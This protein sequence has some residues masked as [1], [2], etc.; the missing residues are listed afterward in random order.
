MTMSRGNRPCLQVKE[1]VDRVYNYSAQLE[2]LCAGRGTLK[3]NIRSHRFGSSVCSLALLLKPLRPT[4]Y[5]CVGIAKQTITSVRQE[6]SCGSAVFSSPAKQYKVSRPHLL[7]DTSNWEAVKRRMY[8]LYKAKEHVTVKKRWV[9]SPVH[10]SVQLLQ[11]PLFAFFVDL[12]W[13]SASLVLNLFVS[14]VFVVVVVVLFM[15]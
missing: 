11:Q 4:C 15:F 3:Q 6:A 13:V 5:V 14:I 7:V 8:Q 9:Y 1:I 12:Y 10:C 2:Q